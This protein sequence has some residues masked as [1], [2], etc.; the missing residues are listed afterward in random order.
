MAADAIDA[1]LKAR[2]AGDATLTALVPDGVWMTLA[3][4]HARR[5]VL[6]E[7]LDTV[8]VPVFAGVG[9][10]NCVY[11]VTA[12]MQEASSEDADAAAARIELL[13]NDVPF[14]AA[15]YAWM[16]SYQEKR[17]PPTLESDPDTA[18][19]WIRRGGE[20][21]IQFARVTT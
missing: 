19:R 3:P 6:L 9:F 18:V 7:C 13:L 21:R 1:G 12:V 14:D 17:V 4:M 15:G 8:P 10:E 11:R 2:L 20:Y 16:T 5:F